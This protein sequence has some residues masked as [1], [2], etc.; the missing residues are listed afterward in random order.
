MTMASR[1]DSIRWSS[2]AVAR[3]AVLA[4]V[5]GALS[6]AFWPATAQTAAGLG[7]G[8]PRFRADGPEA[9]SFGRNEGYPPCQGLA[10]VREQRC[11]V[12]AFSHFDVL[13]PSR[14]VKAS[15]APAR[16][17]RA[18][19][20]PGIRCTYGGQSLTIDQY[21]DKHPVTGF[22]L[23]KGDS[24]LVERYQYDRTDQQ[25]LTSSRWPRPSS[26]C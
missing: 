12:G 16:L 19:A 15:G 21:L 11:R 22:L 26:A 17:G 1:K 20:E 25:R 10:Y 6:S 23:A 2:A 18:R 14:T 7:D 9:E 5:L 4:I 3:A 24:I 13:F 8:G